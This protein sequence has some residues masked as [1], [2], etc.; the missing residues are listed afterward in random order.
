MA[1]FVAK[2]SITLSSELARRGKGSTGDSIQAELLG[3]GG[4]EL[5][6]VSSSMFHCEVKRGGKR[7]EGGAECNTS[8]VKQSCSRKNIDRCKPILTHKTA[9]I[10]FSLCVSRQLALFSFAS[11]R[12]CT[13][14]NRNR[15]ATSPQSRGRQKHKCCELF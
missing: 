3:F 14:N 6:L 15:I 11:E 2:P 8:T 5:L 4:H 13:D 10:T 9:P 7:E 1:V 12:R